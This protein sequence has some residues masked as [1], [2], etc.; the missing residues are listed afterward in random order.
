MRY[1]LPTCVHHK[2]I[3]RSIQLSNTN[4]SFVACMIVCFD[5]SAP[6]ILVC[7]SPYIKT[8]CPGL[9]FI[10]CSQLA[11]TGCIDFT[12]SCLPKSPESSVP[13][14]RLGL[15]TKKRWLSTETHNLIGYILEQRLLPIQQKLFSQTYPLTSL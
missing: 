2:S 8:S 12:D 5:T 9:L 6:P 3:D 7:S 1:K 15:S 11:C 14:S 10:F 13:L 4:W